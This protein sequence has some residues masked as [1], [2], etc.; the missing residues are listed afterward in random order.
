MLTQDS[1]LIQISHFTKKSTEKLEN[2][3]GDTF[4]FNELVGMDDTELQFVDSQIDDI[5]EVCN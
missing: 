1:Y 3:L 4:D 5:A 2:N